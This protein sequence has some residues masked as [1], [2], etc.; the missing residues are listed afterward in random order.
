MDHVVVALVSFR[1]LRAASTGIDGCE[2]V[3]A[4]PICVAGCSELGRFFGIYHSNSNDSFG[5]IRGGLLSSGDC[6]IQARIPR[7]VYFTHTT[8]ANR[9]KN[10][11]RS[12]FCARVQRHNRTRL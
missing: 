2:P 5:R 12:E 11:V 7:A 1:M 10:F 8:R 9:R 3:V 4:I 6:A